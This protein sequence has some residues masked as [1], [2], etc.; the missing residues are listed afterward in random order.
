MPQ[1]LAATNPVDHVVNQH[2]NGATGDLFGVHG[3]WLWSAHVGNLVLAG[4]ISVFVLL[5]AA[6][7]IKTGDKSEGTNRLFTRKPFAHMLEVICVYLRDNRARPLLKDRTDTFMP[8]LWTVFFFI[9]VN[10]L[11]GL[12]P[13]SDALHLIDKLAGKHILSGLVGATATQNL[14]VTGA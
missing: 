9:L 6:S 4:G 12:A 8:F 14:F 1:I 13:I 7:K 10:N 2:L 3:V 5:Y 11:L